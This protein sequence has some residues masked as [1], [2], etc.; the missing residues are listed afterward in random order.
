MILK[1]RYCI[2]TTCVVHVSS[3]VAVYD[4]DSTCKLFVARVRS[5]MAWDR[6]YIA[7]LRNSCQRPCAVHK[8]PANRHQ[9]FVNAIVFASPSLTHEAAVQKA[10]QQWKTASAGQ[11]DDLCVVIFERAIDKLTYHGNRNGSFT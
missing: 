3:F 9:H 8:T 10:Q 1:S 6:K 7:V 5:V 4:T 11:N 2:Y